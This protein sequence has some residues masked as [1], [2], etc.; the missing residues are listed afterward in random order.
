MA[1][2]AEPYLLGIGAWIVRPGNGP[3]SSKPL[4]PRWE[5]LL[6]YYYYYYYSNEGVVKIDS[7]AENGRTLLKHVAK[8]GCARSRKA[9]SSSSGS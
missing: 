5:L 4:K 3:T 9:R 6:A 1:P 7:D 8:H 2:A